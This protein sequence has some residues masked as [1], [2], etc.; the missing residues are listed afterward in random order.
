[1][2]Q[3]QI[4]HRESEQSVGWRKPHS[5]YER[6]PR[7]VRT[8]TRAGQLDVNAATDSAPSSTANI[9]FLGGFAS[10][11]FHPRESRSA[12]NQPN[13]PTNN[14]ASRSPPIWSRGPAPI[15]PSALLAPPTHKG[16]HL[17]KKYRGVL[18]SFPDFRRG[19]S[20]RLG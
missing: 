8:R 13:F 7:T 19:K 20:C 12:Q 17:P 3:P 11:S 2:L 6:R 9:R 4:S 14:V 1:M 16:G 5:P 18:K 10:L 15:K